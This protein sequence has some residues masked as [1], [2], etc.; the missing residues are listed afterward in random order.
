MKGQDG[1]KLS[2]TAS[3]K[4]FLSETATLFLLQVCGS[5]AYDDH[6]LAWSHSLDLC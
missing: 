4:G 5:E 6:H 3:S 1:I 2:F